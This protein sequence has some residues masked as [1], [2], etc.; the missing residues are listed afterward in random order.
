MAKRGYPE[1]G[2]RANDGVFVLNRE[3]ATMLVQMLTE[4]LEAEANARR[5]EIPMPLGPAF[6]HF[7]PAPK[8]QPTYNIDTG[9][10]T[11]VTG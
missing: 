7:E 5:R 4:A 6:G 10:I 1:I 3:G 2:I 8:C 11:W 9:E